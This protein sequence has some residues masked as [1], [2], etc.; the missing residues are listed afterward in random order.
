VRARWA[1]CQRSVN[2]CRTSGDSLKEQSSCLHRVVRSVVRF[3]VGLKGSGPK[4]LV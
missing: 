3:Y 2:P 4:T 1:A